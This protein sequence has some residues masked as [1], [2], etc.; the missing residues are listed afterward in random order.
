MAQ[1]APPTPGRRITAVWLASYPDGSRALPKLKRG[2]KGYNGRVSLSATADF[3]TDLGGR[4]A[5]KKN[6]KVLGGSLPSTRS[7]QEDLLMHGLLAVSER[8]V[9]VCDGVLTDW[10]RYGKLMYQYYEKPD[11][12]LYVV[13]RML[14]RCERSGSLTT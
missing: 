4:D 11:G 8:N 6:L 12:Q 13:S 10:T 9:F 1:H 3:I 14:S 2:Q 7:P 5:A